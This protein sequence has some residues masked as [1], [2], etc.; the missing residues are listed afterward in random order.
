MAL[1][2]IILCFSLVAGLQPANAQDVGL[3]LGSALRQVQESAAPSRRAGPFPL[4]PGLE[5]SVEFWKLV[6]TRYSGSELVFHDLKEPLKIY[7]VLHVGPDV[8]PRRLMEEERTK[9]ARAH[10][11][12]EGEKTVRAQR[13]I[14]ERFANGLSLSGKYIGQI[15]EILRDEGLPEELAYLPLVESSFNIH[16]RSRAGA[17][18][19]WQ[20]TPSTGR[21]F[22]RIGRDLDERKDPLESTRAAARFL[23]ENFQIF[24]N[25][26]LA[27]TAYNHGREGVL[28]AVRQV[29]SSDLMDL[30]RRYDGPGFGFASK[31]FYAEFL[32]AVEV[33]ENADFYFPGIEL[34]PPF[35]LAELEIKSRLPITRLLSLTD[36][37][38]KELLEWNPALNPRRSEI[39]SGYRL[40]APL[41]KLT[42][43][44]AAY[45]RIDRPAPVGKNPLSHDGNGRLW[46]R[47]RV[48]SGE[49]LSQIARSYRISIEEIRRLNG[50]S[51]TQI[52][53]GQHLRLPKRQAQSQ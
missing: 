16:A 43:L 31:N 5:D 28:R 41:E 11:L 12:E 39:P 30:V 40:K 47:H 3:G 35:H 29:G 25:W 20:F 42:A 7:Q 21:R 32:A 17:V 1:T 15:R 2:I 9:I 6:F 19:M 22:L 14:R 48:S 18:G 51:G 8:T 46:T 10:G 34:H 4:P 33:A 37:S 49:T 52:I 26:P 13:G 45:E 36:M 53:A 23:K 24:G 50:L 44:T 38:L 27:I